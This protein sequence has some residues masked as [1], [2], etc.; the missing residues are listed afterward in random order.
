MKITLISIGKTDEQYILE[1]IQKY[2][3]RLKH[4]LAF[5]TVEIPDIKNVKNMSPVLQKEKE[6]KTMLKYIPKNAYVIILD[7]KG[8]EYG[9]LEF[10]DFI[11]RKM[12]HGI[13]HLCFLIGGPYGFSSEIRERAR[14]SL[15]L[16]KLTFSHQMVRLFFVEQVYRAFTIIKGEPYHH[17]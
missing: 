5:S 3:K 9:S 14:F 1:G 15:S 7:E 10:S 17:E 12:L 8:K 2:L 16:S 11:S 6:G 4:Y 13:S